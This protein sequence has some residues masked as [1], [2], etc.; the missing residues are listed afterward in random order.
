MEKYGDTGKKIVL[1]EFGWTYDPVNPSY[2]W[3]GADAGIDMF[4][5]A[6]YLKRAYQ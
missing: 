5:Q 6:D 2:K 1:L 4:V 3:H